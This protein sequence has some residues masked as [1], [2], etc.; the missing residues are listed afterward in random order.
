MREPT[1][2]VKVFSSDLSKIGNDKSGT[3]A[4]CVRDHVSAQTF[5][6][7]LT[8]DWRFLGSTSSAKWLTVQGS[9]LVLQRNECL[10]QMEGDWILFID[11]DM[12]WSPET[13]GQLVTSWLEVQDEFEEPVIMGGLCHRREAPYD[14]TMYA[15]DAEGSGKYRFMEKWDTDIVEVDATGL[16][17]VLIPVTALEAIMGTDW[18]NFETRQLY[19]S[20][21]LF[22]WQQH[23]GEDLRFM[24][25]AKAAGC[26][27]FV[28]TRVRIGHVTEV[29]VDRSE[30]LK[31]VVERPEEDEEMVR[32]INDKHGLPTLSAEEAK[33][34]LIK[35]GYLGRTAKDVSKKESGSWKATTGLEATPST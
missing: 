13:I 28:D 14:P 4:M 18:P 10:K 6:S 19:Q 9:M 35:T 21:S 23:L 26:K 22:T 11:D 1:S 34:E 16:A 29:V 24:Q 7:A 3:V 31:H 25:D 33:D 17:F 32:E 12:V 5:M 20:P 2:T 8:N 27:V 30:F 15:R